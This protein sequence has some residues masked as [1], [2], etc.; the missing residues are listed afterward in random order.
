M[1]KFSQ[2]FTKRTETFISGLRRDNYDDQQGMQKIKPSRVDS[3]PPPMSTRAYN[4]P[5]FNEQ[6]FGNV[7]VDALEAPSFD[8]YPSPDKFLDW[9]EGMD[10][11]FDY[12]YD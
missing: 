7:K 10:Q 3:S 6:Q 5:R 1:R 8:G 9:V 12:R 4:Y 11:Y 2:E